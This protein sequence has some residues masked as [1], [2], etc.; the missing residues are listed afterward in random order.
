MAE[1]KQTVEEKF[2]ITSRALSSQRYPLRSSN[3]G[4]C[5]LIGQ[6][7]IDQI[8][9]QMMELEYFATKGFWGKLWRAALIFCLKND[10]FEDPQFNPNLPR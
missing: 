3:E 4:F 10:R 8:K 7:D 2:P 1:A 6:R 9:S 5:V